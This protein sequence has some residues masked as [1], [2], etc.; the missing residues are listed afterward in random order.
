VIN[1]SILYKNLFHYNTRA[2]AAKDMIGF[3]S[4]IPFNESVLAII[5]GQNLIKVKYKC[6]NMGLRL[7]GG[8]GRKNIVGIG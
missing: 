1:S 2:V 5:Y 3:G 4:G 6:F 8:I 7:L